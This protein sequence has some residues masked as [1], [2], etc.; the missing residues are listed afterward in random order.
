MNLMWKTHFH[1]WR[2]EAKLDNK[3][4]S[5]LKIFSLHQLSCKTLPKTNLDCSRNNNEIIVKWICT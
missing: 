4:K 1:L 2:G 3:R 5:M